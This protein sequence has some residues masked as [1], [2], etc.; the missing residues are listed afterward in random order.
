LGKGED[1]PAVR[2][3]LAREEQAQDGLRVIKGSTFASAID[4]LALGWHNP[5]QGAGGEISES[6]R[7]VSSALSSKRIGNDP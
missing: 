1:S 7:P 4:E 5:I 6:A 3:I 2:A